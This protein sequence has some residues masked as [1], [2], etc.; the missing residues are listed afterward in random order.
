MLSL[1]EYL[2]RE[3]YSQIA[4]L[5]TKEHL[6]KLQEKELSKLLRHC[7]EN[8]PYYQRIFDEI[9]I[10]YDSV[11][12]SNYHK[13]PILTKQSIRQYSNDLRLTDLHRRKWYYVTS[14]GSTGEPVSV[15]HDKE[16][17]RW[18]WATNHYYYKEILGVERIKYKEIRLWG[19][20]RDIFI[21]GIG[22]KKTFHNFVTNAL[23]LNSFRMTN[24]DIE[25]YISVINKSHPAIVSGYAGS[26]YEI[27]RY[28]ENKH[29]PLHT[30]KVVTSGAEMVTEE[31]R[32]QIERVFRVKLFDF[33]GSRE[34]ENLAGECRDGLFHMFSFHN[35]IEVVDDQNRPVCEGDEGRILVTPLHNYTMPLIRY[36]IG[37]MGILGPEQCSCGNVLPTLRKV[38]GRITDHFRLENGTLIHG[39]YFTH[40]FYLKNWVKSFQVI[41]EDYKKIRIIVVLTGTINSNDKEDIEMKMQ[42]VMGQDCMIIWEFVD[43][44]PKTK[45]GKYLYT[46]SLV[47]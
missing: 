9:G 11:D 32:D 6:R 44:I 8:V 29:I 31:V 42:L 28:A 26:L 16:N 19:N 14:G 10:V 1:Y 37:D 36:E 4:Q 43:D 23:V 40:L 7:C 22:L 33:Y 18:G 47:R 17:D 21:G 12:F 45:S 25:K 38:T 20:E 35:L 30:P 39:E 15:M 34:T 24:H 27:C 2:I 13:I 3:E 5:K 41:Q 46:K